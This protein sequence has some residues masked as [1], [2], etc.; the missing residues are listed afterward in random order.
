MFST[1]VSYAA[2]VLTSIFMLFFFY[3]ATRDLT[4]QEKLLIKLG[5]KITIRWS[6]FFVALAIWFS[7]GV[8]LWG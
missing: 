3:D 1:I 2:F 6:N 7:S 8:Y 5:A 4:E